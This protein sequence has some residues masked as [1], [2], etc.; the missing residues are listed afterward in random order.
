MA[1]LVAGVAESVGLQLLLQPSSSSVIFRA[2]C[3]TAGVVNPAYQ[4]LKIL[5]SPSSDRQAE[6]YWLTYW[7]VYATLE[8]VER[9]ASPVTRWIPFYW[10]LK[11]GFLLWLQLPSLQGARR[12]VMRLQPLLHRHQADIDSTVEALHH[13]VARPEFSKV[14]AVVRMSLAT[15]PLL[16]WL[17]RSPEEDEALLQQAGQS[18]APRVS[19]DASRDMSDRWLPLQQLD[20]P[21]HH[22]SRASQAI[23]RRGAQA[24]APGATPNTSYATIYDTRHGTTYAALPN[25]GTNG[26]TYGNHSHNADSGQSYSRLRTPQAAPG[27]LGTP[28]GSDPSSGLVG[29]NGPTEAQAADCSGSN[30]GGG[31][32][33]SKR[34]RNAPSRNGRSQQQ[35]GTSSAAWV[36]KLRE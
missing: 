14:A 30:S 13:S 20:L 36:P 19:S 35:P 5:D 18:H 6:R 26:N 2:A 15:A 3:L 17:L 33:R 12:L 34:R 7:A 4:T 1:A 9:C 27:A 29:T 23:F 25:S 31:G 21:D 22:D 11:F 8:A 10:H 32:G 28:E 16:G 24:Y